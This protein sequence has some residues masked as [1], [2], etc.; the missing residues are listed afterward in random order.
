MVVIK[1][2]VLGFFIVVAFSQFSSANFTPFAPNGIDGIVAG[3]AIIF[4]PTLASTPS[5]PVVRR[6]ATLAGICRWPSSARW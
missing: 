1:L 3:T 4:L 2:A 5:P 6:R